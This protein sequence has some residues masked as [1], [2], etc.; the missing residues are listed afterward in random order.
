MVGTVDDALHLL[1]EHPHRRRTCFVTD[2]P[3]RQ[4]PCG[5]GRQPGENL[6]SPTWRTLES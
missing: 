1:A 5:R 4:T 2:V 3:R 6:L